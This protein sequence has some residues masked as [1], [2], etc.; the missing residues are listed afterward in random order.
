MVLIST[1]LPGPVV[2]QPVVKLSKLDLPDTLVTF[3]IILKLPLVTFS[4]VVTLFHG[5]T[6][7][8]VVSHVS[9]VFKNVPM[10]GLVTTKQ[11]LPR[12][13]RVKLEHV[14]SNFLRCHIIHEL[15]GVNALQRVLVV[16]WF[17][18]LDVFV[19]KCSDVT[20][21][22]VVQRDTGKNGDHGLDAVLHMVV[23]R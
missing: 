12:D 9:Q 15:I 10:D 17:E 6:G 22:L 1:G 18:L 3:P 14:V 2:V 13:D 11:L 20:P 19:V 5:V 4:N 21:P 7:D 16:S 8:H 23:N